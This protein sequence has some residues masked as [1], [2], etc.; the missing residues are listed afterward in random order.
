MEDFDFYFGVAL[1]ETLL[2]HSDNLSAA[3]QGQDVSAAQAQNLAKMTIQT[4]KTLRT[5]A[6]FNL[7]WAKITKRASDVGVRQPVLPRQRRVPLRYDIGD[8]S[9]AHHPPDVQSHYRVIY[10]QAVDGLVSTLEERF[11]Q[12]DFVTY[13]QAQQV[14]WKAAN[15]KEY[16]E[17]LSHVLQFYGSDFQA[18]SLKTQL[19][20]FSANIRTENS[21][22][23][24]N[25]KDIV[26]YFQGLQKSQISLMSFETCS[27]H[28]CHKCCQQA[29]F[30]AMK[31]V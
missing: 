24:V 5:D 22:A 28:A 14:L 6:S 12:E 10:F 1:G 18:D 13:S 23:E 16:D 7:F 9:A 4:L 31:R 29:F 8:P 19:Q 3:L 30:G 15:G 20:T 25:L 17:E 21:E 2:R 27:G 26:S 11:N